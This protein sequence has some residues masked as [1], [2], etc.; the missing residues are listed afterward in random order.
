MT[1]QVIFAV[2]EEK[3]PDGVD[4]LAIVLKR[5]LSYFSEYESFEGLM[6][7]LGESPWVHI[8]TVTLD[9]FNKESP[10]APFAS[11]LNL[12]PGFQDV[13]GKMTTVDPER[14]ITAHDALAH[15]WFAEIP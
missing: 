12:D 13:V 2:D 8:F 4:K 10:R 1:K 9:A 11:W 3:L 7:Y 5:Q 14:R 15:R 6:R